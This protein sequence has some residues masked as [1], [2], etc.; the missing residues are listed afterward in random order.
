[1]YSSGIDLDVL[2][3]DWVVDDEVIERGEES[4]FFL[5]QLK[6]MTEYFNEY[7]SSRAWL[8]FLASC[9]LFS[10]YQMRQ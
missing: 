6:E 3:F 9:F 2:Y 7:L 1:M 8:F 5:T 10:G 4:S